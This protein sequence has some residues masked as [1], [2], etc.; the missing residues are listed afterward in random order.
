MF[1]DLV[2][3]STVQTGAIKIELD[4]Y[5]AGLDSNTPETR[6]NLGRNYLKVLS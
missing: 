1:L 3:V 4:Q 5:S 2:V 6:T